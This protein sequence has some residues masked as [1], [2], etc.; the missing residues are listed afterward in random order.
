MKLAAI[1]PNAEDFP[2]RPL[3]LKV[4]KSGRTT[5][6]WR[7]KVRETVIRIGMK[8]AAWRWIA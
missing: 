7:F 2:P 5:G 4:G 6:R 8:V 3:R 1:D